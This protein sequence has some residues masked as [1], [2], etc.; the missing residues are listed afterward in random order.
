MLAPNYFCHGSSEDLTTRLS[1]EVQLPCGP[2]CLVVPDTGIQ[3]LLFMGVSYS[4]PHAEPHKRKPGKS[5]NVFQGLEEVNSGEAAN[6]F[7]I[8]PESDILNYCPK[9]TF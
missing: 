7:E 5:E 3:T 8:A 9:V 2:L 6:L 4:Q 1:K